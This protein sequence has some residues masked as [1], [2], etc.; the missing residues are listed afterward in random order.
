MRELIHDLLPIRKMFVVFLTFLAYTGV[1]VQ[2]FLLGWLLESLPWLVML[3][4]FTHL[5]YIEFK[6]YGLK[7]FLSI[8]LI[9]TFLLSLVLGRNNLFQ[10]GALVLF[11]SILFY[12]CWIFDDQLHNRLEL[13]SRQ[14]FQS[15][16]FIASLGGT[17]M[18]VLLFM[19]NHQKFDVTCND[20]RTTSESV[21]DQFKKPFRLGYDQVQ[22]LKNS[23]TSIASTKIHNVL[24][25]QVGSKKTPE[26][27]STISGG[28]LGRFEYVKS[29][30]IDQV[31]KDNSFVNQGVCELIVKQIQ[32]KYTNPVF[33]TSV[34]LLLFLL[35]S[36]FVRLLIFIVA[37]L[38]FIV[39]KI[40]NLL[41]IYRF[42]KVQKLW[43]ELF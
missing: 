4:F 27:S 2:A 3:F 23:V 19:H 6:K 40:L 36:P 26:V 38:S 21:I 8:L 1:I 7:Y 37:T 17:L 39:F 22:S 16:T 11:H 33:Q 24:G 5:F 12:M 14:I 41:R 43:E 9:A 31:V 42:K 20:V 18:M 28:I 10:Q 32:D 35:I 34:I 30:I 15:G 29:L 13:S 25:V